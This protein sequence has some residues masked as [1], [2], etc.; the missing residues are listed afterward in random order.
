[1]LHQHR[2][3]LLTALMA[4]FFV[5]G[6]AYGQTAQG[7]ITGTVAGPDGA[8]IPG[9]G[10][11]AVNEQTGVSTHANSND[12]GLYVLPFLQPGRYR[13]AA[14][15]PGFKTYERGGVVIE[16]SQ[17]MQLNIALEL[18]QITE[19][20]T[21]T[22]EAPLLES[23]HSTVGQFI[24]SRTVTD[25]PLAGRRALELVRLASDVV[26]VSYSG[27]AKPQFAVS[28]GRSYKSTYMLDGGNIQN[29]RM[30][31]AQVDIDPPVEVIQEFKVVQNGYAAEYGGSASGVLISTTKSG[32]NQ[33]RGSAFEFFRND[34]MDAAGFFAP[35]E[36]TRK[37]KAPLRYNLFGGTL[38]GPIVRNRTH[39]FAGYEGTRKST[40][41]TQIL[42]LPSS[43]QN[44]GDF[45]QTFNTKGA[46]ITIYDPATNKV[47][48]GKT[49]RT[50][51]PGNMIPVNRH[52]PVA[53]KIIQYWPTPNRAPSNIAGAQNFAGNRANKFT[54][55]NLTSRVDHVFTQNNRIFF[56]FVYNKDPY[57]YTSNYPGEVGDPQNPISPTRW[58]TSYFVQDTIT[59][60]PTLITD[61]GYSFSNRTWYA[62]SAG[63]E[64][65][66]VDAVGLPK[67]S[68]G[69]FP[70]MRVT[71]IA[72]LGSGSERKQ[73]PIRQHQ[74]T[75]SWTWIKG[76]HVFKFG[77]EIRKG[78]NVDINRPIISGNFSFSPTGTAMPGNSSTGFGYASYLLGFVNGF[79]TRETE[80]LDK[81]SYYLA[82][83]AQDDWKI[84]RD[85]TLNLG[86]R[87]ET[88]TP[89]MDKNNRTNSFDRVGINPV[90]GTPGIVKFTGV[91]GWPESPWRTD[92]NNI[93][94]RFGLAWK[95]FGSEKTVVRGG[96]GVFFEMP[97]TSANAA[98]LG[99]ELSAALSSP[100]N[101]VT[102]AF[103]LKDG[104]DVSLSKQPLDDKFGA[105]AVGGKVNTNVTFYE[106]NRRTGY[107]QQFN[108]GIQR[109]MPANLLLEARYAANLARK[110]PSSNMAINQVRIENAGAGNAQVKRPYPQFN[111]VS[112]LSPTI[113]SNNYHALTLRA[114]K[115]LSQGLSFLAGYTWSRSI[116]DTNN[117]NGGLGDDQIWQDIYNRRLDKGPDALDVVHH[118]VW[119]STYDLP[120]GKG[121]K[122]LHR[123]LAANALGGWTIGSVVNMQSG[124]PFTVVTQ[125]NTTN[126]FS[127]GGQRANVIADPRLPVSE[128]T[129]QRWFNTDAFVA[130]AAYTFGNA[131]RGLI[132][133]DGR[134]GFDFSI[135]KNFFFGENKSVTFRVDMFNA[136]NHP[137]FGLPGRSLG[138]AGFGTISSATD[139]RT[140]QLGLRVSF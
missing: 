21:V 13:I 126:V 67:V 97:S 48:G 129:V 68:N 70:E 51:F 7:R 56:R 15:S 104:P 132:R 109:Q 27:D 81:Y 46:L 105:V 102:P 49:T 12:V 61:V 5:L 130:P 73:M 33:Y 108:L 3:V 113:G 111:G 55:D 26:F 29:I 88:D 34:K 22:A 137:D 127:A 115:R 53:K 135:N 116:G 120:W 106:Q 31:S 110:L 1:M 78:I 25:M 14:K 103:Y 66:V 76:S 32:T 20:V 125:A 63:L 100:D 139:P 101:G 69:S 79:S 93:G 71:G 18:G 43:I 19:T 80:L 42:T 24:D 74:V 112:V 72:N 92:W 98:T 140:M 59:V 39:F 35:T 41:S 91:N 131:G 38:G 136:F 82:S 64:S 40:G 10:I 2:K 118:F 96:Y 28:G 117:T 119:S 99:F 122:W 95:P 54:R 138:G 83:Y 84:G 52:D 60:S 37:I 124:G 114:E 57:A 121:R 6:P 87:W 89:V 133:G 47:S 62:F 8:V 9:A 4:V 75:N 90:S 36:G 85:L 77:G 11:S 58:E 65:G 17:V 16:T 128:R 23:S 45:S 123:G 44:Q 94:P 107:A 50:P 30:A 134:I 86:V